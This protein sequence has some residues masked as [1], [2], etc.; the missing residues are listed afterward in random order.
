MNITQHGGHATLE[1]W[2]NSSTIQCGGFK[3]GMVIDIRKVCN[4]Y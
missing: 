2:N 4:F 3:L 1:G